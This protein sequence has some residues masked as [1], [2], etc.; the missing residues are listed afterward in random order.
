MSIMPASEATKISNGIP[1]VTIEEYKIEIEKE[2]KS[3]A[4]R[5]SKFTNLHIDIKTNLGDVQ[6]LAVEFQQAGYRASISHTPS[7]RNYLFSVEW[8]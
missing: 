4:E 6:A 5:G 2:I 1:I 3:A 7:G 8:D